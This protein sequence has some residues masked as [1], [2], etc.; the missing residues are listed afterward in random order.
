MHGNSVTQHILPHNHNIYDLGSANKNFKDLHIKHNIILDQKI[1]KLKDNSLNTDLLI[2]D[3]NI[4]TTNLL[5]NGQSQ[6]KDK[7]TINNNVI[8]VNIMILIILI[9]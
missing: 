1:I 5:V 9:N 8:M 2:I 6:F 3:K 4:T 7:I